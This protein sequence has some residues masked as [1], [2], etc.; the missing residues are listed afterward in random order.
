MVKTFSTIKIFKRINNI[1]FFFNR[2]KNIKINAMDIVG[3]LACVCVYVMVLII[4]VLKMYFSFLMMYVFFYMV[5]WLLLNIY[6]QHIWI[7]TNQNVLNIKYNPSRL[8]FFSE[9][10]TSPPIGDFLPLKVQIIILFGLLC[11]RD[12]FFYSCF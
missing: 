11:A 12:L 9:L 5:C 2:H 1:M 3:D 6:I 10:F 8:C 7:K 4:V